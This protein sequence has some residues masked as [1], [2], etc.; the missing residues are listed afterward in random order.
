VKVAVVNLVFEGAPDASTLVSR[1]PTLTRFSESLA[2]RPG[3]G[4]SVLQ[5]FSRDE[6]FE[7]GGVAYHFLADGPAPIPGLKSRV[8]RL[9]GLLRALAPDVVHVN[10]FSFPTP[11]AALILAARSRTVFVVQH[12]AEPPGTGFRGFLQRLV[13]PRADGFFFTAEENAGPWREKRVLGQGPVFEVVEGSCDFEPGDQAAARAATGL[14]GNPAVL[15]VGRLHPKKDPMTAVRGFG[16]ALDRLP[17]A[18]LT[19]AFAEAPLLR[20]VEAL[21][22]S[23]PRL[24]ERIRLVGRLPHDELAVWYSAADLFLTSSPEEGSNYALIEAMSCGTFPVASDIPPHRLLTGRGAT[25]ELF[26]AGDEE[27]CA[28]ALVNGASR[29]TSGARLAVRN[30]FEE[31]ASWPAIARDAEAAYRT[32]IAGRCGIA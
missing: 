7:R 31:I 9:A 4:V 10:G 32:L 5:R 8:P 15:W 25:G 21:R 20:E 29:A 14:D 30:R 24:A 3:V 19:M 28:A 22:R 18:T 23:T 6:Y 26:P 17:G 13:T 16:L 1:W 27:A 12:H 2:S 11:L